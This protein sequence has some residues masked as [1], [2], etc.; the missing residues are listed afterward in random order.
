MSRRR[1]SRNDTRVETKP[2]VS[3]LTGA[4]F[5]VILAV[6][7]LCAAAWHFWHAEPS[8]TVLDLPDL[9]L[10][11]LSPPAAALVV[12]ALSRVADHPEDPEA[13]GQLGMTFRAQDLEDAAE[14]CFRAA[15]ELA[16][17]DYRWPYLL[18]VSLAED[19]PAAARTPLETAVE[20]APEEASP[21]LRLAE[22][23]LGDGDLPAAEE[24]FAAVLQAHPQ[25]PRA[26]AGQ[27]RVLIARG[28]N[29]AARDALATACQLAPEQRGLR[30][31]FAQTLARLGETDAAAA[32]AA[33][34]R[35]L[36][37]GPPAWPDPLVAEMLALRRDADSLSHEVAH[38]VE[39]GQGEEAVALLQQLVA[40]QPGETRW[41]VPLATLLIQQRNYPA[42]QEFLAQALRLQ[43][44]AAELW[45]QQGVL[46][47]RQ[48]AW[49]AA[50]AAFERA[51]ELKPDYSDAWYNLGHAR[52]KSGDA[53][54]ALDAFERSAQAQS[55]N[56]EAL[57]NAGRLQLEQG[58]P[59]AAREL[60]LRARALAPD[61]AELK[62]LW[63]RCE[64]ALS[65]AAVPQ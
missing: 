58:Q 12:E 48:S 3:P 37:D 59:E 20:L 31:A 41:S 5:L 18:A 16:P 57:A 65:G 24:H 29:E 9:D 63:E 21:R 1:A 46:A 52:E 4:A 49:P 35:E 53:A 45:L 27:A 43:P 33:A 61:S 26:L 11:Q 62:Q 2:P 6:G 51:V 34:A 47:Y 28:E 14:K 15:A 22:M 13:V 39:N 30:I 42:A 54:G 23:L 56:L 10:S 25:N 32:E 38:L 44:A 60:L 40:W 17:A 7:A 19:D 36:P 50:C 55:D 64:S 8:A